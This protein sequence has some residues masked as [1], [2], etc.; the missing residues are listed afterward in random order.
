MQLWFTAQLEGP[1]SRSYAM[2]L[3]Y[4]QIL[5]LLAIEAGNRV[6]G[7]MRGQVAHAL[8]VWLGGAVGL[9]YELKLHEYKLSVTDDPDSDERLGRRLWWSLVVMDRWHASSMSTPLFIPDEA[10]VLVPEDL[11]ILGES[12]YHL[13][14]KKLHPF[15]GK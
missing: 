2:N 11:S 9:A 5:L 13:T 7:A 1:G 14:R 15:Y 8:S 6:P 10:L 4:L 12:H 3:A